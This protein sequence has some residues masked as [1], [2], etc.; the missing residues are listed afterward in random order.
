MFE[1]HTHTHTHSIYIIL[2][3]LNFLKIIWEPLPLNFPSQF[4]TM[5][6]LSSSS[7]YLGHHSLPALVSYGLLFHVLSAEG[8]HAVSRWSHAPHVIVMWY[9]HASRDMLDSMF[10][11]HLDMT[12]IEYLICIPHLPALSLSFSLS[13][14]LSLSHTPS[15]PHSIPSLIRLDISQ[16]ILCLNGETVL[17]RLQLWGPL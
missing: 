7:A 1:K 12:V 6:S 15:L 2:L 3:Q 13:L 5:S 9:A 10:A 16:K 4:S 17:S 11:H 14:S 8:A